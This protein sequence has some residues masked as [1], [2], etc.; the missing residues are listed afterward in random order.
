MLTPQ[1]PAC[2]ISEGAVSVSF[3]P[4]LPSS[5]PSR[6]GDE[7]RSASL[8]RDAGCHA[9]LLR[10]RGRRAP[11]TNKSESD[12]SCKETSVFLRLALE[13]EPRLP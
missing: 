6:S 2:L 5:R 13:A 11:L 12:A 10:G 4:A 9:A 7:K 1:S 3:L 8:S